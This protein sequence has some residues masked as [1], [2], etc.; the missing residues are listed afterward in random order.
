MQFDQTKLG[1]V[2][3]IRYTTDF[4]LHS[5]SYGLALSRD[6]FETEARLPKAKTFSKRDLVS[7]V[8]CPEPS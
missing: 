7:T 4:L 5:R 2:S 8:W 6:S 3:F 1:K